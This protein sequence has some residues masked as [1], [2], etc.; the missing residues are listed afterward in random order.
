MKIH[1]GELPDGVG[2]V[3]AVRDGEEHVIVNQGLSTWSAACAVWELAE[4][5]LRVRPPEGAPVP[6]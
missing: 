3:H 5:V 4:E 1:T 6:R 2:A